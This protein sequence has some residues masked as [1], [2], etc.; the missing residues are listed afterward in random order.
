MHFVLHCLHLKDYRKRGLSVSRCACGFSK[1]TQ[2]V[3]FDLYSWK[4]FPSKGEAQSLI[5]NRL[6]L[7]KLFWNDNIIVS[8]V[9]QPKTLVAEC[10]KYW[11]EYLVES[12]EKWDIKVMMRWVLQQ[13]LILGG[14]DLGPL[15]LHQLSCTYYYTHCTAE[16]LCSVLQ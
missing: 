12:N 4:W 15:R 3:I 6:K 11:W 14:G 9:I 7:D 8:A 10:W 2:L 1:Q 5:S 13:Q 16:P